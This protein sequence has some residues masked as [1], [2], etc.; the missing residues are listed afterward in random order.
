[1]TSSPLHDKVYGFVISPASEVSFIVELIAGSGAESCP[2]YEDVA[3][4]LKL[5]GFHHVA[6]RISNADIAVTELKRRDVTI[7]SEAHARPSS[8]LLR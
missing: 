3:S 2:S 4:S 1:M 6:F 7:V 5:S 8:S